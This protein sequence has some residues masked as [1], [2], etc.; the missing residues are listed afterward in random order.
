MNHIWQARNEDTAAQK[1][2]F[3]ETVLIPYIKASWLETPHLI[4]V[5]PQP[6][7]LCIPG[8]S[9]SLQ[10]FI[11]HPMY[12]TSIRISLVL[13]SFPPLLKSHLES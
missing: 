9:L 8:E 10:L 12:L 2:P 4:R 7:L 5:T 6:A 11:I 3:L 13:V 1:I